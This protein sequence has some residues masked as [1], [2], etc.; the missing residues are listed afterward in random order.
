M[1]KCVE[2]YEQRGGKGVSGSWISTC[3]LYWPISIAPASLLV[4][5]SL[6]DIRG[7]KSRS[8][9]CTLV[10]SVGSLQ[11]VSCFRASLGELQ[12]QDHIGVGTELQQGTGSLVH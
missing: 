9:T 11:E 5:V 8:F 12:L 3:D 4:C 2:Q 7:K 10:H 6:V 1:S